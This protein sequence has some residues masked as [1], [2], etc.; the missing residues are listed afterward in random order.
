MMTAVMLIVLL[1]LGSWQVRR[2]FWKQGVLAEIA[3]A[4]AADP[5]PLPLVLEPPAPGPLVPGPPAPGPLVPGP[6]A[7]GTLVPGSPVPLGDA[8]IS[9]S[10]FTKIAVTGVFLADQTALYGA[11]VRDIPSGPAMGAHLIE[12]LR[13]ADGSVIL[14]DRGWVPLSRRG[15]LDQPAGPVTV[16]GYARFGDRAAWFSAADDPAA[17][18]FFT[19]DPRAIGNAIGQPDVL[20]FVLIALAPEALK[21]GTGATKAEAATANSPAAKRAVRITADEAADDAVVTHWPDAARHLPR[22]PNNHLSYVITWY[23]L[24]V[25]L[26]AVFIVWARKGSRE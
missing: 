24:A 10:P 15:P 7:P 13:R 2:L 6:P 26:L 12:P 25:A 5:L 3:R 20:P 14:V 16:S 4:E 19:L 11:E 18:R 21:G 1:G 22:P 9:P 17:R 8:G 23:G